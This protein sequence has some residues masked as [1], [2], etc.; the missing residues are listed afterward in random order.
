MSAIFY[1]RPMVVSQCFYLY[2]FVSSQPCEKTPQE[3][4]RLLLL[5]DSSK[6]FVCGAASEKSSLELN[7]TSYIYNTSIVRTLVIFALTCTQ[8]ICPSILS[9]TSNESA[10]KISSETLIAFKSKLAA[11]AIDGGVTQQKVGGSN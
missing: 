11:I 5:L 1:S 7:H 6:L 4:I 3:T 10:Q 9:P 2:F 8:K